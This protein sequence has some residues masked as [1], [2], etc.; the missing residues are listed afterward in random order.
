[1]EP[2]PSVNTLAN[3][4]PSP[5][6]GGA[7]HQELQEFYMDNNWGIS[8]Y[9]FE[10]EIRH[11]GKG[12]SSEDWWLQLKKEEGKQPRLVFWR[13]IQ[14]QWRLLFNLWSTPWELLRL[15]LELWRPTLELMRLIFEPQKLVIKNFKAHFW[16]IETHLGAVNAH[17]PLWPWRQAEYGT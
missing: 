6:P 2:L 9:I 1:M 12:L 16:A 4:M 7:A 10:L 14:Q 11:R 8:L 13:L 17:Q 15:N 5:S 3:N